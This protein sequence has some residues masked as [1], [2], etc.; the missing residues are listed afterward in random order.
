MKNNIASDTPGRRWILECFLAAMICVCGT[1]LYAQPQ[2]A[3]TVPVENAAPAAP[4]VAEPAPIPL[5]EVAAD[6]EAASSRLRDILAELSPDPIAE[7]V[8]EQLPVLTR[9][10]DARLR[11]TRKIAAQRASLEILVGLEAEWRRLRRNLSDWTRDLTNRATW[12]EHQIAELDELEKTW[13]Q[14]L[15]AAKSSNAP[16]EVLRRIEAV[17]AQ[18]GQVR[19]AVKKQRARVLTLQNRVAGQ[20][21]RTADALTLIRQA[22]EDVLNRLLVKDSP[23][24]WSTEV[25]SH[26]PQDVLEET[27]TSLSTQWAA[28]SVYVERQPIRFF[29]HVAIFI[30]L[31]AGLYW[32][33]RRVRHRMA[34]E[35]D[36]AG[37]SFVFEMPIASA[38]IISLQPLDLPAG[39]ALA[40]GNAGRRCSH[41]ERHLFSLVARAGSVSDT[42][43]VGC[44]LL[45]RPAPHSS[46]GGA[47]SAP[48]A[49]LGRDARRHAVSDLARPV[50][51]TATP[52]DARNRT[53]TQNN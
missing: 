49:V 9:E 30:A 53:L 7:E 38:L 32:T 35:T 33:R 3:S 29:L 21:A 6:A 25:R 14:T 41:S 40:V 42:V 24:I 47:V 48:A 1:G 4:T 37:T 15:D 36:S 19:E 31:A 51:G 27:W 2:P 8:A 34:E 20:E 23:A 17:I 28:L 39:A 12:L 46:G 11:E 5:P 26:A 22:R 18:I 50:Y 52:L 43:R 44:P 16:P 10:I 45:Y 13:E